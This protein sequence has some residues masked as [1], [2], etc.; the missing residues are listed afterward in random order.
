MVKSTI[1]CGLLL[2]ETEP[3][4]RVLLAHP[5]G[6]FFA[7]KDLGSWSIPKGLVDESDADHLESAKREFIEETGYDLSL[8]KEYLPLG[9]VKLKSGKLV[10][11][12]AFAGRW[13]DGRVPESNCFEIE[14]PPRSG[15][16]QRFPE[17]DRA[18]MFLI[19]EARTRINERQVPFLDRLVDTIAN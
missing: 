6:P 4:L 5:G 13:E 16:T 19:A 1:S 2:F 18:E 10:H 12:W 11:A 9:A 17:I 14:W 7:K 3:E 15:R 8:V